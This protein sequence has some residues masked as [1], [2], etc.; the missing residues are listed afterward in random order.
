MRANK[1]R[2]CLVWSEGVPRQD[3]AR[4]GVSFVRQFRRAKI[5]E[6]QS[7]A[8]KS[9]SSQISASE[10]GRGFRFSEPPAFLVEHNRWRP[11][12]ASPCSRWMLLPCSMNIQRHTALWPKWLVKSIGSWLIY[13]SCVFSGCLKGTLR[14]SRKEWRKT[15]INSVDRHP[16]AAVQPIPALPERANRKSCAFASCKA[17]GLGSHTPTFTPGN[18]LHSLACLRPIE[19]APATSTCEGLFVVIEVKSGCIGVEHVINRAFVRD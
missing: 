7:A 1:L 4:I 13:S 12:Q 10:V 19:P 3:I 15:S 14:C 18:S 2:S 6:H 5:E 8:G 17:A 16:S 9:G 11:W